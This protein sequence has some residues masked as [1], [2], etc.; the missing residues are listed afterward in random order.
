R[1]IFGVD[2]CFLKGLCRGELLA[3][4]GR[5]GNNQRFAIAW[6]VVEVKSVLHHGGGFLS[7][8]PHSSIICQLKEL[9]KGK[10]HDDLMKQ[11]SKHWCKAYMSMVPKCDIIDNNLLET[12]NDWILHA[13][14]ESIISMLEDIRIATTEK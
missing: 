4:I 14:T 9:N 13:R 11:D 7:Y 6:A 1:P 5:D 12:F 10:P 8:Q 2:G 3:I